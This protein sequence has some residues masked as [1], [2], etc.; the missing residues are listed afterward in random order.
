M[1]CRCQSSAWRKGFYGLALGL[2]TDAATRQANAEFLRRLVVAPQ[3]DFRAG[4]DGILGGY[5]LL[6]G[7]EGLQLVESRYLADPRAADG[8]V[9]HTMT[10]LRFYREYGHEIP[11]ERLCAALERLLD[12]SEFAAAAITDLA[13]WKAWNAA[14]RIARLYTAGAEATTRRAVVGYLLA[15]PT[16]EA[17][18]ELARLRTLDEGGVAEAQ[19]ILSQTTGLPA[20][21]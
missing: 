4:F 18:R 7:Q 13:R 16:P 20:T 9:R 15:C 19:R 6:A 8:D 11:P 2:S 5:L 3:D 12:R 17:A 21:E 14:G 10:A 1:A